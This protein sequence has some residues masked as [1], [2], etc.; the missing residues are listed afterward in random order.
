MPAGSTLC[1]TGPCWTNLAGEFCW[2]GG[3][4]DANGHMLFPPCDRQGCAPGSPCGIYYDDQIGTLSGMSKLQDNKYWQ[5][6]AYLLD[7]QVPVDVYLKDVKKLLSP[8]GVYIGANYS[9]WDDIPQPG[10]TGDIYPVEQPM[11]G[12]Y[13]PYRLQTY[14]N[15]RSNASEVDLYPCG[16]NPQVSGTYASSHHTLD[17]FGLY[18]KN[19]DGA[20][21]HEPY[22]DRA[23]QA[24]LFAPL[25]Y[26]G[27]T[28]STAATGVSFSFFR[29]HHHPASWSFQVP[30]GISFGAVSLGDFMF[31]TPINTGAT[32]PNNPT[33]NDSTCG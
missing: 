9:V 14:A 28:G 6:F 18:Y 22:H 16:Y 3:S 13:A 1:A 23:V 4:Y 17:T 7:S 12:N 19:E 15:L 25:G 24:D 30:E 5:D 21:A 31:L 29:V 2:P 33:E 8:A 10:T 32:S 26:S 27:H 20:T 11:I